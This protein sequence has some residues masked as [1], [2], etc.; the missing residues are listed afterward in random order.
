MYRPID[1]THDGKNNKFRETGP[2][3]QF[4]EGGDIINLRRDI[5]RHLQKHGMDTIA[6]LQHPT[7]TTKV[8]SVVTHYS[9]FHHDLAN[10]KLLSESFSSQFDQWDTRNDESAKEFLTN[11]VDRSYYN[12]LYVILNGYVL[13]N[14]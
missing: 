8:E 1:P 12:D 9:L 3:C 6:Y 11:S 7:D 4:K 2:P 10:T 13:C 5:W 14:M